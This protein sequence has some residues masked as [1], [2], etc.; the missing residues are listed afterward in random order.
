MI[1]KIALYIMNAYYFYVRFIRYSIRSAYIFLVNLTQQNTDVTLFI[2]YCITETHF[3][4]ELINHTFY[5]QLKLF[6]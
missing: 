1:Y 3:Y 6:K 5:H 2:H 4:H